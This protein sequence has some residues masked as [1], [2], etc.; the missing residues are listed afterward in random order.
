MMV[1]EHTI[2]E[3]A[4]QTM[5]ASDTASQW[6]GM[7][8]EDVSPGEAQLSMAVTSNML[9]GFES[10]HGGIIFSLADTAFAVACNSYNQVAVAASVSIDFI[11]PA[12]L[13]DKLTAYANV[14]SQGG[15]MGVYDVSVCNQEGV[16]IALF[17]GRSYR[18]GKP[19]FDEQQSGS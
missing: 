15:R 5:L 17:R 10:C 3:K 13:D 18:I 14:R 8:L 1:S 7:S 16:Q 11:A 2:A 6:L 19:V 4:A 9:N 12:V